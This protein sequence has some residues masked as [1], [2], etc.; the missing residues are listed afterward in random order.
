MTSQRT[1]EPSTISG[2]D[3]GSR[4]EIPFSQLTPD[5]VGE[6][7]INDD[8]LFDLIL[9]PD[10]TDPAIF[11]AL[12]VD[13]N[14]QQSEFVADAGQAR[15]VHELIELTRPVLAAAFMRALFLIQEDQFVRIRIL[16]AL[17][18]SLRRHAKRP[19]PNIAE[20]VEP[21]VQT[22]PDSLY[23]SK[24][25]LDDQGAVNTNQVYLMISKIER[26]ITA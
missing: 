15:Y 5:Q 25:L 2:A 16:S 26:Q 18:S 21:Q 12:V 20:S 17:L 19:I 22:I 9:G 10:A 13:Y 14:R 3:K 11:D 1:P 24:G 6:I 8:Q 7:E 23:Q 4:N